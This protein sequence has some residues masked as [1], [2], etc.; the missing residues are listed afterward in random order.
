MY[1]EKIAR[2]NGVKH[3]LNFTSEKRPLIKVIQVRLLLNL[4][5]IATDN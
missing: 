3:R 1:E 2:L 4:T 5:E